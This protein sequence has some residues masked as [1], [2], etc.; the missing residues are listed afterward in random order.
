MKR[1][2]PRRAKPST[3]GPSLLER[4]NPNAAGID[5]GAAEHYVAVPP[6]RD[7]TPVRAF[8][9]FTTDLHCLADWLPGR[10]RHHRRD[11]IH[12]GLLDSALR[13]PR[14]PGPRR[15]ARQRA[16]RE[17]RPGAVASAPGPAS[18]RPASESGRLCHGDG[19]G[20]TDGA[21]AAG[22]C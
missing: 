7:P 3:S 13:D 4:L 20:P 17:E 9:T 18:G 5:C 11:G 16:A 15:G 19:A 1:S 12:R 21:P 2:Q 6:D 10:R 22:G 14:G 8:K